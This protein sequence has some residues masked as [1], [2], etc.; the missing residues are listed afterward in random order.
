MKYLTVDLVLRIHERQIERFGGDPGLRDAGL[1]DSA[2]AQPRAA[3]GGQSLYPTLEEKAAA[4]AF[5]LVMNHPFV[6]GNKRTAAA[7]MLMFL[8]RNGYTVYATDE[9][10]ESIILRTAAGELERG[11]LLAW[12]RARLIRVS[13]S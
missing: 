10:F 1:L 9:E 7:A 2:L 6:D 13:R 8:S 5:S 11:G 12:V 4:L 3:F